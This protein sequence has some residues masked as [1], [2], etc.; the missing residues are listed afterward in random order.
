[1]T[2]EELIVKRIKQMPNRMSIAIADDGGTADMFHKAKHLDII[3][4]SPGISIEVSI[5]PT[6]D[7]LSR[8]GSLSTTN[9]QGMLPLVNWL[10]RGADSTGNTNTVKFSGHIQKYAPSRGYVSGMP[11]DV[12]L[13]ISVVA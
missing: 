4:K 3:P 11:P 10:I 13:T 2:N 9:A 5:S 12:T 7:L 8:I 1:M 6:Q